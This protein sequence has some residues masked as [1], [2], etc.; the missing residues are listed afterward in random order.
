MAAMLSVWMQPAGC[1]RG[2]PATPCA[3]VPSRRRATTALAR[4]CRRSEQPMPMM[5]S[6]IGEEI[7]LRVIRGIP[8]PRRRS[9]LR[10]RRASVPRCGVGHGWLPCT[11]VE[12]VD[13]GVV[14]SEAVVPDLR[15]CA[16]CGPARPPR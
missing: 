12:M 14:R 3:C 7:A 1:G 8:A 13:G 16:V 9:G 4:S 15:S 2:S 6:S 5:T 11:S 10:Y